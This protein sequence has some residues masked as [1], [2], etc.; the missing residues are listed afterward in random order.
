MKK[1]DISI[2]IPVYNAEKYLKA[3]LDSLLKQTY[4]NIEV[5]AVNDGSKDD[6]LRILETYA[7]QDKRL[8]VFSQKNSGP[9][10]ARNVGLDNASGKYLMFCDADDTYCPEMCFECLNTLQKTNSDLVM[11]DTNGYDRQEK[12]AYDTYYFPFAAGKADLTSDLRVGINVFLW[13]KIFRKEKVDTYGIRFPDGHKSDDNSFVFQ[14]LM[15]SENIYFLKK[16]LYNHFNRENSIMDLFCNKGIKYCDLE[17][18]IYIMEHLYHFMEK[19][20]ILQKHA[21]SF[22]SILYNE[23]FY[24][25]LYLPRDW[26]KRFLRQM[27]DALQT[28]DFDVY[29]ANGVLN[30]LFMKIKTHCFFEAA[31]ALDALVVQEGHH[32][33]NNTDNAELYPAFLEN[34]VCVVFNCDD[35]F[36]KYL[37]V[38]V[39]SIQEHASPSY[40]YDLIVLER[41]ISAEHKDMLRKQVQGHKNFSLRFF[42]M[43]AYCANHQMENWYVSHHIRMAA[44]YRLFIPAILGNYERAVYL[45]ADLIVEKD[46]AQL[47]FMETDKPV[48]GVRD[49][50]ISLFTEGE[51]GNFPGFCK[52]A[53]NRLGMLSLADYINSGVLLFNIHRFKE[54]DIRF[55]DFLPRSG[56]KIFFH[57]QDIINGALK[58]QIEVLDN[59]W[60]TQVQ[61]NYPI[62]T[63]LYMKP[64]EML[65]I[66]HFTSQVK[67]WVAMCPY[68]WL[69]WQYARRSPFYEEI[70]YTNLEHNF[71]IKLTHYTC[72]VR[73]AISCGTNRLFLILYKILSKITIGSLRKK[74]NV[75]K[76]HY[77]EKLK[78]ALDFLRKKDEA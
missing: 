24:A 31:N 7:K 5:I 11:C 25:W 18:K 2:I 32:L 33:P 36:A 23:L 70:L 30:A 26:Q 21:E 12:E 67:P 66:I 59:V 42:D 38:T 50:I 48:A 39:Q 71:S 37:S 6:S 10:T 46:I 68:A 57:D 61:N 78:Q 45:D 13:N 14:Y 69:W 51:E 40:N 58:G 1:P 53:H 63:A 27:A 8:R 22:K 65:Y 74:Y 17:D 34:N 19:N 41:E 28:M 60:N 47:Y 20:G 43:A 77:K 76:K 62:N 16:G 64:A 54:L 4:S 75:R 56:E 49:I 52:Y 15:V 35:A 44:Y 73:N 29:S 55:D 3:C 72:L 9:A